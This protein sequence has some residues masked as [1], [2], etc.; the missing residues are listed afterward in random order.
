MTTPKNTHRLIILV[1]LI[2]L[3]V[4]LPLTSALAEDKYGLDKTATAAELKSDTDLPSIIGN[5]IYA[6]LGFLGVVFFILILYGGFTWMTARG[7]KEQT[8]KAMGIVASAAIGLAIVLAS[9]A[10]TSFIMGEIIE[11]SGIADT[12]SDP[13]AVQCCIIGPGDCEVPINGQCPA[14]AAISDSPCDQIHNCQP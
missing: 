1:C 13:A 5:I 6:F 3:V 9:Y 8:G 10:A 12:N 7:N 4:L 11:S 14:T 2:C